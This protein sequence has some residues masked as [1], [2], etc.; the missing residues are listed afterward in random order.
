MTAN[1]MDLIP[2]PRSLPVIGNLNLIDGDAP[3]QSLIRLAE[4]HGPIFRMSGFGQSIIVLGSQALVNEVC[5]ETRFSKTL[6]R[7]LR[8]LRDLGGDGLFTAYND[9]PNW[10]KAHRLLM[11]AFGPIGVRAMFDRMEEIA[12]Q[13]LLRWE[14]FGPDADIDVADNMTR[15]TLDTIA[16]CAFDYR[17]NSFYQNE[18]HPFVAAMAGALAEAGARARR[19]DFT[20]GLLLT[21]RRRYEADL[22]LMKRVA[23]TIIQERRAEGRIGT[24]GDLLDIMLSG[25]DPET[26]ERLSDTNIRHQLVTFLIAGHETT[27]G[28]LSFALYFLMRNPQVMA[29]ARDAVDTV[30]NGKAPRVEDL[31]KLRYIEQILQEALR[32]WP[33]APA[34]AVTPHEPTLL[35]GRYPV[36]PDDTL[37][38]LIPALHRDQAVWDVP[39]AFRPERFAPETAEH[40]PPNAWKPFGNGGRACIGRGFAMQE[41]QMVLTMILQRFTLTEVDPGYQLRIAETLT[42]KADGFRIHAR[43][44]DGIAVRARSKIPA[45]AS[46]PLAL[47]P[48]P[49]SAEVVG[50]ATT[51]LLILYGSNSGSCEAF[52]GRIAQEAAAQ[53]YAA[54]T[55]PL[56]DHVERLPRDGAV[57]IVTAS[58]EGQPPDNA[59]RFVP[60][61]EGLGADALKGVCFTVFGCGN[62]QWARTYQAIPK[63]VDAAMEHAGAT[64]IKPRGE[65]DAAGD[66]FGGFDAWYGDLWHDLGAA[67]GKQALE[68]TEAGLDVEIVGSD[69]LEALRLPDLDQGRIL[70]NRELVDMTSPLARSKRH[71][72]I[73]L[74][75]GM[76]YRTGDYLAVLPRNPQ[77]DVDRVLRRFGLAADTQVV[78]GGQASAVSLPSG[79]PVALAQVLAEYVE[80][81][82]PATR[83]QI[84]RLAAATRCPPDRAALEALGQE[85][86]YVRDVLARRV[87][88]LD[89]LERFPAC[90]LSLAQFLSA[91][92]PMRARQYS[93]SSS[94]LRDPG[95]CSLTVAV[96]DAPAFAGERRH[97]GVTS[98]YLAGLPES[99]A[100]SVAVRPSQADF[101][102]PEDPAAPIILVCAGSGIAPFHG[103]L[104]ERAI[105][106]S[107]GREVGEALLFFGIDHPDVDYLYREELEQWQ[108]SGIVDVRP[109]FSQAPEDEV[110]YVQHRVWRDRERIADLFRRG[111]TVFVCGDG[112]RMAPAVRETFIRIYREAMQVSEEAANA[113]ADEI[114]REHGRYVADVFS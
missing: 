40:L 27:S 63:R 94:P 114:E 70:E 52:A 3:V 36:T 91:L 28:L 92:P 109:A 107:G 57:I 106:K 12:D 59:R 96:L 14:R 13:M 93:I 17:F 1:T 102:P 97:L 77:V 41:A 33:T 39:E 49:A 18:M 111:A 42:L 83:A 66:F 67:L 38:V 19:P 56:D 22:A 8:V 82:Q 105:Q 5:D 7:P 98:T 11:P 76:R 37:L 10:T 73:S 86:A 23:E 55:A 72:E 95:R 45:S 58:Y 112:E 25:Q 9:E 2:Q 51:P 88:L 43:R 71:I 34:F 85:A 61:V 75:P 35:A 68:P 84:G 4:I 69:R 78:I 101:H 81:G 20:N 89:L 32:L 64:R 108:A 30:L 99:A 44:R 87:S 103:F 113:W 60:W 53:G 80:L 29:R 6:H 31:A 104:Q 100:V 48:A 79:Y 50:G 21:S 26:G 90:E 62:R 46:R 15:L 65:T 16:L 54:L 74:P 110:M 47:A 24:R